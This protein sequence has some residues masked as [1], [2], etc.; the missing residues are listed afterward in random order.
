M[1]FERKTSLRGPR[2]LARLA[3]EGKSEE[4]RMQTP[5]T[6]FLEVLDVRIALS[7]PLCSSLA[8][9]KPTFE[10]VLSLLHWSLSYLFHARQKGFAL[11][12]PGKARMAPKKGKAAT[13]QRPA[14]D[15]S[16]AELEDITLESEVTEDH[17]RKAIGL[18]SARPCRNK[19]AAEPVVTVIDLEEE[20]TQDQD[21]DGSSRDG[22]D[23]KRDVKGKGKGKS[24]SKNGENDELWGPPCSSV[25]CQDNLLCLNHL[26]GKAVSLDTASVN[27]V[28][29]DTSTLLVE[30]QW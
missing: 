22:R 6:S 18:E 20:D 14:P 28:S 23:A 16:W 3:H 27:P 13:S 5:R 12:A 17:L 8:L 2:R 19:L 21:A 29:D 11:Y 26:G 4:S 1:K 7:C 9:R 24:K 30:C 10:A 25:W 15:W